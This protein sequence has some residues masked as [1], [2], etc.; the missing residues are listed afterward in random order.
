[1]IR[2]MKVPRR[3]RF[4]LGCE[5]ES[6]QGY[7]AF[8]DRLADA[9]GLYVHIDVVNL[10]PAGD[11]LA[12]AQKA[13]QIA[14]RRARGNPYAARAILFDADKLAENAQRAVQV[15]PLLDAAQFIAIWQD[16]DHEAFLLRHFAGH[17]R[18]NP[19]RGRTTA[20]LQGQWAGYRK[21]MVARD[22]ERVLSFEHVQRAA[23]VTPALATLLGALGLT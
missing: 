17:E 6:E 8:L 12:L 5:G 23:G 20:A 4:F 11:P 1:M 9:R 21:G 19:P 15:Q 14:N 2:R 10:Q 18:D 13:V 3:T 16:Q 7:G 22:I